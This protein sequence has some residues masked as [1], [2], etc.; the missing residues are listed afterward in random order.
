[1]DKQYKLWLRVGGEI[2]LTLDEL[3]KIFSGDAA[4]LQKVIENNGFI[5]N[6]ETYIHR[7]VIEEFCGENGLDPE[8]Y[9]DGNDD[10]DFQLSDIELVSKPVT[11]KGE[12]KT[13]N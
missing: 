10:V 8:E 9:L 6:G 3:K 7:T 2:T 1:M 11:A 5:V 13:K 12:I 4:E